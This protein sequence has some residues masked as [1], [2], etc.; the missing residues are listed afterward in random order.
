MS[1]WWDI[2]RKFIYWAL[3]NPEF[4]FY[5]DINTKP[6]EGVFEP[7]NPVLTSYDGKEIIDL[8][9]WEEIVEE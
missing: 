2:Y 1:D 6:L 5:N 4:Y 9:E 3:P 8:D 7:F